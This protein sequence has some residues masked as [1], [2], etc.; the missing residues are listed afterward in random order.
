MIDALSLFTPEEITASIED[1]G[2][3]RRPGQAHDAQSVL[4]PIWTLITE[5]L[6]TPREREITLIIDDIALWEWSAITPTLEVERFLRAVRALC[7]QVNHPP[8]VKSLQFFSSSPQH[9]TLMFVF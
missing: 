7:R 8:S 1:S 4:V 2:K 6:S 5:A 3:I 9:L